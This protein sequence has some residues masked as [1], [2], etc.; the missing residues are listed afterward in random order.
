[1]NCCQCQGIEKL[2]D[3]KLVN[4][5]LARYHSKGADKTTMLMVAALEKEGVRGLSVLDIGGGV[6]A[7]QHALLDAGAQKA[8]DVDASPAYLRAARAEAE[9][10][11]LSDRVDFLYGN[12]I[13]LAEHIQHADIVT[14]DR[15]ICCYDNMEKMVSL[16]LAH[17]GKLYGMVYP[18]DSWW[19]KIGLAV[20]NF[21]FKLQ[22]NPFRIFPHPSQVVEAMIKANGLV[23]RYYH[24]T[25]AWQ[26]AVYARE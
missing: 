25:L 10:R 16:S 5:D 21:I 19:M 3:D 4:R 20:M 26:V 8:M 11:G 14:L 7:V 13:D 1:M 23:R 2:F 12:F 17:A 18:R 22:R 24:R 6:G 15:V 9:R